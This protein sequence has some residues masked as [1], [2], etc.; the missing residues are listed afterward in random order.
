MIVLESDQA[1]N[2]SGL[3]AFELHEILSF[4]KM[5]IRNISTCPHAFG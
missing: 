4:P 5:F 3:K 1:Q 2:F